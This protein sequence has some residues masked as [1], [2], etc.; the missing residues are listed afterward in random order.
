MRRPP[1]DLWIVA[2]SPSQGE[3]VRVFVRGVRDPREAVRRA[4]HLSGVHGKLHTVKAVHFADG[5]NPAKE[6]KA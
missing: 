1:G 4:E 6:P 5:S 2:L 3:W